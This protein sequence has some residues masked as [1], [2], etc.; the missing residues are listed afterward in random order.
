MS[1][2]IGSGD[3]YYERTVAGVSSGWKRFGNAVRFEIQENAEKK[4]RISR[5]RA[6]Y[7]QVLDSVYIKQPAEISITLDDINRDNLSLAFLGSNVDTNVTGA[8]VAAEPIT[9]SA[10][11]SA[12]QTANLKISNITITDITATTTYVENTDYTVLDADLGLITIESGGSINANE[13]L[14]V[15]YDYAN[16]TSNSVLGGTDSSVRVKLLLNGENFVDQSKSQV[17]VW[18]AVLSPENGIDF[19]SDEFSE[20]ELTGSLNK[21]D[22][23]P[24]AYVVETDIV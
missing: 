24:S 18:D 4:E 22:N 12:I 9:V 17:T 19:L 5:Q 23:K 6:S 8:T 2:F 14:L 11:G 15:T 20:I 3:L 21:P 13:D 16:R 7:G 1:G 10:L